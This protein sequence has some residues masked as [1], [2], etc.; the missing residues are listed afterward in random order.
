MNSTPRK[1]YSFIRFSSPKQELGDSLRRQTEKTEKYALDNNLELDA[2][3]RLMALGVSGYSG[4]HVAKG[5]ALGGFLEA[6]REEKIKPGTVLIVEALDR[7]GRL[8]VL[9][10]FSIFAD[11]LRA[12]IEIHTLIDRQVYT[13]ESINQNPSQIFISL[14]AMLGAHRESAG[15]GERISQAWGQKKRRAAEEKKCLTK[16]LP[17]W[18]EFRDGKIEKNLQRAA[19]VERIFQE[20]AK[21]LGKR[22]IAQIL[23]AEKVPTFGKGAEWQHSYIHKI[24]R[25]KATLGEFQMWK[26][27]KG[28]RVHDGDPIEGYYPPVVTYELWNAADR[29]L[30]RGRPAGSTGEH[31]GADAGTGNLFTG[32][33]YSAAAN[34]MYYENK[35]CGT[36]WQ[37]LTDRKGTSVNYMDF[38]TSV[39]LTLNHRVD[40]DAISAAS[41]QKTKED[42]ALS[43]AIN[44]RLTRLKDEAAKIVALLESGAGLKELT[45][46]SHSIQT[47][48]ERLEAQLQ[49]L[50]SEKQSSVNPTELTAEGW[51]A[52]SEAKAL[53]QKAAIRELISRI[54][55]HQQ[56]GKFDLHFRNGPVEKVQLSFKDKKLRHWNGSALVHPKPKEDSADSIN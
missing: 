21:G 45:T 22:K 16:R 23:N 44:Q 40:W 51:H 41:K 25:N 10:M 18:L 24:L 32:L 5:S 26:R 46:K 9:D 54:V 36:A 30:S 11:I 50:K 38:L 7:L 55:V 15:R 20:K 13:I 33:V 4:K 12:G 17:F 6:C 39:F 2:N 47:E 48:R 1:A 31:T 14:G 56:R 29:E 43:E 42:S 8:Q 53:A 3:T 52:Q 27:E 34:K 35:G 49:K 28:K 19:V 37:Y